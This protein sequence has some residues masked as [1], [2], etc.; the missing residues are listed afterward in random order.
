MYV[1]PLACR[2]GPHRARPEQPAGRLVRAWWCAAAVLLV[3]C[4][5]HRV[6]GRVAVPG[7]RYVPGLT[8]AERAQVLAVCRAAPGEGACSER[9]L[10]DELT[11]AAAVELRP[12]S[13]DRVE[14]SHRRYRACVAA[15]ACAAVERAGCVYGDGTAP[16]SAD[17]S[18]LG[19][20]DHPVV[21]VPFAAAERFCRWA[22]GR[23]PTEVEWERAAR[24]DDQRLFPWG[25]AWR[26][27][28]LNWGDDGKIDGYPL[29]APVGSYPA[30]ASPSGAL[31]LAGNVWEW[32][33]RVAGP[34]D[35]PAQAGWEVIRGGGFAAGPHAMRATKRAVYRPERGY[36]NVGLRCAY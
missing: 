5:A 9:I 24:G 21:C 6:P 36:P 34:A 8:E 13:I 26:P 25:D 32:A 16:T 20:V 2:V 31:D 15:G 27:R 14:V 29:T 7:G 19:E 28:A 1:L 12:F 35:R 17:W 30:G 11:G 10:H 33:R 4:G 23:L 18:V 22:G 3:A